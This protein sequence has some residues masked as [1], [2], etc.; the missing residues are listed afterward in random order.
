MRKHCT[1]SL[2]LLCR[3]LFRYRCTPE[4]YVTLPHF[5]Y[6]LLVHQSGWYE[7]SWLGWAAN[8]SLTDLHPVVPEAYKRAVAQPLLRLTPALR[9]LHLEA[10]KG[11]GGPTVFTGS[12]VDRDILLPSRSSTMGTASKPDSEDKEGVFR[13]RYC[14]RDGTFDR[15]TDL[16]SGQRLQREQHSKCAHRI[17]A[18][19]KPR[20]PAG[21][22][23]SSS[24]G[25]VWGCEENRSTQWTA[26]QRIMCYIPDVEGG[27]EF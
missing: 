18:A 19:E 23:E 8:N 6:M 5:S 11:T 9:A 2:S 25:G 24:E 7:R 14:Q 17:D 15:G 21:T 20:R 10:K 26:R 13:D 4:K 27:T 3:P 22:T 1:L 16:L 12:T